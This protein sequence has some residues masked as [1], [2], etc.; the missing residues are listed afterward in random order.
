MKK[1]LIVSGSNGIGLA[2]AQKLINRDFHTILV[3]KSFP[4]VEAGLSLKFLSSIRIPRQTLK[5]VWV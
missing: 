2:I 3:D 4:D 1:A 5:L